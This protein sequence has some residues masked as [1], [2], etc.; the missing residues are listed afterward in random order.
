[1]EFIEFLGWIENTDTITWIRESSSQLGYTLYLALHTIGLVFLLG[2]TVIIAARVFDIIPDLP[3]SPMLRFRPLMRIGFWITTVSGTVLFCTAPISFVRNSV[4]IVKVASVLVAYAILNR[5]LRTVA[6]TGPAIDDG[7]LPA[8]AKRL[9]GVSMAFW[10]VG[11]TAGRLTAY[12]ARVVQQSTIA[13]LIALG[14]VCAVV[15][16]GR[17]LG[18]I[19]GPTPG[20]RPSHTGRGV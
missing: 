8:G 20:Y 19:G 7:P 6:T 2:P 1:V 4:F 15:V 3:L 9:L 11:V 12:S 10:A 5:F 17:R 13:A 18:F 14:L 16:A